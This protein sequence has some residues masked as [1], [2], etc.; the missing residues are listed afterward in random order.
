MSKPRQLL[1]F[2]RDLES[3]AFLSP[4]VN[5]AAASGRLNCT[6]E[7][8]RDAERIS[9]LLNEDITIWLDGFNDAVVGLT[10]RPFLHKARVVC[11]LHQS[12]LLDV[13]LSRC[14]WEF[15]DD[16]VV[17]GKISEAM[18]FERFDRIESM[19]RVHTLTPA[20]ALPAVNVSRKRRTGQIVYLAPLRFDN[21]AILL[22][23]I[24]AQ[25]KRRDSEKRLVIC[26]EFESR[27]LQAYFESLIQTLDLAAQFDFRMPPEDVN[28][29]LA[30]KDA[31]ICT[32][33]PRPCETTIVNAMALGV[34]P[35]VHTYFG[36]EHQYPVEAL[37]ATTEQAAEMICEAAFEPEKWRQIAD[38]RYNVTPL[39]ESFTA[40]T[41]AKATVPEPTVSV[42]L[43]TFNRAGLLA[44]ALRR[45]Q[46]QTYSNLEIVVVDDCSSDNTPEVVAQ[47]CHRQANIKAIRNATNQGNAASMA[48]AAEHATGDFVLVLSDDDDLAPDAVAKYVTCWQQKPVD[49]IYCDLAV[50]DTDGNDRGKWTYKN[51]Y[52]NLELLRELLCADGNR[53][54][55]TFFCRR[56]LYDKIYRQTYSRRFLNT[57]YLPHL[58][59][60]KMLHLPEALYRYAIH[61]G[62][63]F[64]TARGLFD[65]S[66]STQN[67]FNAIL[68]M[69]S[70]VTV[71]DI[72][73]GEALP[74]RVGLAYLNAANLLIQHGSR[75]FNGMMYTGAKFKQSDNLWYPYY[76]NAF[77]WLEQASKYLGANEG[78]DELRREILSKIDLRRF[79]PQEHAGLPDV[80]R[81][82]PWFANRCFNNMS[83]FVVLDMA[84]V[85]QNQLFTQGELEFVRQ[86]KMC[87]SVRNHVCHSRQDLATVMGENVITV[88]N[89]F[90]A[91]QLE[92]TIRFLIENHHFAAQ[93]M[94]FT[95]I[96]VP[97]LA[98]LKNIYNISANE[99]TDL[100]EYIRRLT[101]L[102]TTSVYADTAVPALV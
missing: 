41:A 68:F 80:Y 94:N 74:T 102:T 51:Y 95:G 45:L 59:H 97:Q 42:L 54:P 26:G 100:G 23:Q 31:I 39:L 1:V 11:R 14:Q 90:D 20:V 13:D 15:F 48:L 38:E 52:S 67:Y 3:R 73:D 28:N 34:R 27:A 83:D 4:Y 92:P 81:A 64:H 85:G 16:V 98:T 6:V 66:K 46:G 33:G 55:E 76:Y 88:V 71:M 19:C 18:L 8:E 56:E 21:N 24:A 87:L 37:F 101:E 86:G 91:R 5:A 22:I 84:S 96:E 58:R 9:G 62:S 75:R 82:L 72:P 17:S 65:R 61:A 63:T 25:L 79:N 30:D 57:Y 49:L 35:I 40:I 7:Y 32:G 89:I 36:A 99:V 29:W 70:P 10:R 53:I 2:A 44:E 77:F 47:A 60:L 50:I 78:C 12:D 43:P 69:Y 93:V